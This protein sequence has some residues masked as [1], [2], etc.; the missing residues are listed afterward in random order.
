M[1]RIYRGERLTVTGRLRLNGTLV[2]DNTYD[3]KLQIF[4][5]NCTHPSR[6]VAMTLNGTT[7]VF[8]C[9]ID[10]AAYCGSLRLRF[11]VMN[12]SDGSLVAIAN[13]EI[14]RMIYE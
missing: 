11:K 4:E 5:G 3:V 1:N 9:D 12:H 8:S 2:T 6:E 10:T 13:N 7:H 14:T